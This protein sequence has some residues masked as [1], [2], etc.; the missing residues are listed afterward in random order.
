MDDKELDEIAGEYVL[1]TL[2]NAERAEAEQRIQSDARFAAMVSAWEQRLAPVAGS[3]GEIAPPGTVWQ[4]INDPQN[5]NHD[6][7]NVS[8][9]CW[10]TRR[11][12]QMVVEFIFFKESLSTG[13]AEKIAN[14]RMH[15]PNV[16]IQMPLLQKGRLTFATL[17]VSHICMVQKVVLQL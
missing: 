6:L 13:S 11:H 5:T 14:A 1:G 3:I 9:F 7:M 10:L 15:A 8:F 16:P 12:S 17:E 2:N 4:K